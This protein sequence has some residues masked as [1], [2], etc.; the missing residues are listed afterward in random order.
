MF[1]LLLNWFF[2]RKINLN[3][4]LKSKF[5]TAKTEIE[6]EQEFEKF[7]IGKTNNTCSIYAFKI[8]LK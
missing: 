5:E 2:F 4:T 1:S 6:E 3:S 8:H 7:I